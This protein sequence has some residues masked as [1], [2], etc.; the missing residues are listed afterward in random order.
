MHHLNASCLMY[1]IFFCECEYAQCTSLEDAVSLAL[2][3]HRNSNR[4]HE[5]DVYNFEDDAKSIEFVYK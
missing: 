5:V 3:L 1:K 4:P 2:W